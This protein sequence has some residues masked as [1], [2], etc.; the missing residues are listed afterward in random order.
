MKFILQNI[1]LKIYILQL[2]KYLIYMYFILLQCI[3][4]DKNVIHVC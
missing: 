1:K 3:V 4:I 2:I